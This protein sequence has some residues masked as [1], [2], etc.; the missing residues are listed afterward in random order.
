MKNIIKLYSDFLN[1]ELNVKGTYFTSQQDNIQEVEKEFQKIVYQIAKEENIS[2]PVKAWSKEF[3]LIKN[4]FEKEIE[5]AVDLKKYLDEYV[6]DKKNRKKFIDNL[7]VKFCSDEI[8]NKPKKITTKLNIS[9]LDFKLIDHVDNIETYQVIFPEDIKNYILNNY[10]TNKLDVYIYINCE[11][12]KFNRLHFPG[13]IER[14]YRGH[15]KR[16]GKDEQPQPYKGK[17]G[18]WIQDL[19]DGIP[20][21][22]RGTG[23]GFAIY[24]EFIKFKGYVSSNSW[25]SLL[26][27]SVWKK[28]SGD[29]DLHGILV[30]YKGKD[31]DIILFSKNFKGDYKKICEDF[32]EKA[33][34][35]LLY[36]GEKEN[37]E[38]Q[39]IEIDP[40][41]KKKI[42]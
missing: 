24:K 17:H 34:K 3:L 37:F 15:G 42:S 21:S 7:M 28:L 40:E 13:R 29:P 35:G 10:T 4:K 25:S 9:H 22:L 2:L 20:E 5:N 36:R 23:I 14:W 8:D 6:F 30:N 32:I 18:Q 16:F 38:I 33:K 26:S 27:K 39:N 11:S 1:E 31:G 12:D 41:I 19:F